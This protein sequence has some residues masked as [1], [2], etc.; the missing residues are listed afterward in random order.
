MREFTRDVAAHQGWRDRPVVLV[1][2]K[3][4][5]QPRITSPAAKPNDVIAQCADAEGELCG[6]LTGESRPAPADC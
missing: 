6:E 1:L 2:P 3:L 4:A 5:A